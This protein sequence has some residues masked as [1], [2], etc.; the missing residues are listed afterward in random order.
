MSKKL[1]IIKKDNVVF[2]ELIDNEEPDLF[3]ITDESLNSFKEDQKL[4]KL[5]NYVSTGENDSLNQEITLNDSSDKLS[6]IK[7]NDQT[8]ITLINDSTKKSTNCP[9]DSLDQIEMKRK[10]YI[11]NLKNNNHVLEQLADELES[12]KEERFRTGKLNYGSKQIK[13]LKQKLIY[14]LYKQKNERLN[15]IRAFGDNKRLFLNNQECLRFM[16]YVLEHNFEFK[17]DE[18]AKLNYDL[19]L[20]LKLNLINELILSR[21]LDELNIEHDSR[22]TVE[23]FIEQFRMKL[24][25]NLLKSLLD[26]QRK[27]NKI[28]RSL[29]IM[30]NKY[31]DLLVKYFEV[32]EQKEML[33]LRFNKNE[34]LLVDRLRIEIKQLHCNNLNLTNKI[35][36]LERALKRVQ[37]KF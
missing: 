27:F 3:H 32:L 6:I 7:R 25:H 28:D 19:N 24:D 26:L 17:I 21:I 2:T 33:K 11:R 34:M 12:L 23:Q 1:L 5:A 9:N 36:I 16:N 30:I 37:N 4:F 20:Y 14:F 31:N 22:A 15:S 18:N 35:N 29:K 13:I 8:N 10:I